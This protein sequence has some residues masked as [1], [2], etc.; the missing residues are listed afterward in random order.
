MIK[1]F[2]SYHDLFHTFFKER[3]LLHMK[4]KS[5]LCFNMLFAQK[6]MPPTCSTLCFV[7]QSQLFMCVHNSAIQ[8]L[9][10]PL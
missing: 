3:I 2:I 10:S 9:L 4:V 8:T 5:V 6:V 1:Q 7:I